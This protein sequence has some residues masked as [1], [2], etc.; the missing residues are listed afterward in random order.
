[1]KHMTDSGVSA[2][3]GAICDF[4]SLIP[5]MTDVVLLSQLQYQTTSGGTSGTEACV[6]Y[7][8]LLFS[9]SFPSG[10]IS[11]DSSAVFDFYL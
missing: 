7:L 1:M 10:V 6:F 5:A 8:E 4:L 3:R 9:Y 2:S 11:S